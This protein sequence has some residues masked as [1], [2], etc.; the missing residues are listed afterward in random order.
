MK[1]DIVNGIDHYIKSVDIIP[2]T[3][4]HK[5]ALN[6]INE[7]G[8]IELSG[9]HISDIKYTENAKY[10][11]VSF[12]T[13]RDADP[14][15]FIEENEITFY[16]KSSSP[17]LY[18][19]YDITDKPVIKQLIFDKGNDSITIVRDKDSEEY[20]I[21][22]YIDAMHCTFEDGVPRNGGFP[23]IV[24]KLKKGHNTDEYSDCYYVTDP[25]KRIT[26]DDKPVRIGTG[27]NV[28]YELPPQDLYSELR[29]FR[30][31]GE[32]VCDLYHEKYLFEGKKR[33]LSRVKTG[34]VKLEG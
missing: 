12:Y 20:L 13:T 4:A 26:D 33:V 3:E 6:E 15:S 5:V 8:F 2:L 29:S 32:L 17:N 19:K 34:Q 23:D 1:Y 30:A 25:S 16:A 31:I 18:I 21:N 10:V 14:S 22:I 27:D 24:C 11:Y 9:L 28:E 7:S